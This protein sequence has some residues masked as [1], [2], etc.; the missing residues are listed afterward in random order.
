V[1]PSPGSEHGARRWLI[2]VSLFL[3]TW[4][5]ATLL[6]AY[7]VFLPF[8]VA[9]FGW[10]RGAI[11]A[12]LSINLLIGGVAGLAFGWLADRYGPRLI[13][14]F[15]GA[16][17]G[18]AYAL[19]S[20][21]DE[22]WQLQL[23]VGVLGGIGTSSFYVLSATTIARWFEARRGIALALVLVGFNLGYVT[24]GPLAARLI[25]RVGWPAA[26]ATLG[27]ACAALTTLAGL[28]VRL[29]RP[30]EGPPRE[31]PAAAAT[32]AGDLG[33]AA[34]DEEMTLARALVD[35]RQWYLNVSWL[36]QGGLA[37]MISVHAVSFGVDQG[38]SLAAASLGLTAYGLGSAIGRIAGGATSD[39][40]G[41]RRAIG[42]C[43]VLEAVGLVGLVL[44]ASATGRFV[45]LMAV[46]AG[47]AASD[48]MFLRAV[49]DVFGMRAIAAIMGVLTL[50]WR[51]G[52]ALGPMAAGFAYDLTGSYA[53]VFGAA[54]GAAIGS[55]LLFALATARQRRFP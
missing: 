40:F 9:T 32:R 10:S 17:S 23:V 25:E 34:G 4:S 37:L 35:R 48:T 43:Y 1:S 13:L 5:Q 45:S 15:T 2:V 46:G 42:V 49:P 53:V 30:G 11:S 6:A 24:T 47:F 33:R 22:L 18:C 41:A 51:W 27:A 14:A 36:L 3:I 21:V 19:I 28:T 29:P 20:W 55:W 26:L 44:S 12:A 8:L 7:G 16:L 52:A 50:G 39:R 31:R 38:L 54:P